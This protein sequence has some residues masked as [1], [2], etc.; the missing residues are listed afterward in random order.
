MKVQHKTVT[1]YNITLSEDD[2]N[3][4]KEILGG[5]TPTMMVEIMGDHSGQSDLLRI[6]NELSDN[7]V[8]YLK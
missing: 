3:L 4:I 2:Y 1:E 6:Y 7:Q 5:I 8:F